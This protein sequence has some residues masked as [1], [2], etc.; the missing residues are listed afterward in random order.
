[1]EIR[2]WFLCF[3]LAPI[4]ILQGQNKDFYE[5]PGAN[6]QVVIWHVKAMHPEGYTLDVKAFDDDGNKYDVK[7]LEDGN[8]KYIMDVKAFVGGEKLPV[9]VLVS[10]EQYKPIVAIDEKG[11]LFKIMAISKD[12]TLLEVLGV[13]KSGYIVHIKAIAQDGSFY[14]VKAI[15]QKG[16]LNDVKGIKMYDKRLEVTMNGVQVHAHVVALPQLQ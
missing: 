8:Q 14:G 6:Q 4:L 15:S 5:T 3:M 16:K 13:R 1:V 10:E 12:G 11:K 2:I 7:A 9:K